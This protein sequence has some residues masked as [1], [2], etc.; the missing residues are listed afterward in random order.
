MAIDLTRLLKKESFLSFSLPF[1]NEYVI[2]DFLTFKTRD[3][4]A[5][6][7]FGRLHKRTEAACLAKTTSLDLDPES[8]D[9]FE[10]LKTL[11]ISSN[12]DEPGNDVSADNANETE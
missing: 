8:S 11:Q 4:E 5:L 1:F 6:Q 7:P 2:A 3:D 10:I 9:D 12:S